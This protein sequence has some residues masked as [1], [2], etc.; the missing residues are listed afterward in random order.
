MDS[1][2]GT[3]SLGLMSVRRRLSADRVGAAVIALVVVGLVVRLVG[4]GSRV[5]HFDEA[6]VAYFGLQ[7]AN[8]GIYEYRP[9]THGPFLHI[10]NGDVMFPL[11]GPSDVSARLI[12][13]LVGAALPAL[14]LL[15]RHRLRPVETVSMAGLL[16]LT[17]VIVYYSRFMRNDLL[18]AAFMLGAFGVFLRYYETRR[19]RYLYAGTALTAL[20]FTTKENAIVYLVVWIGATALIVDHSA[21]RVGIDRQV[22]RAFDRMDDWL[23]ALKH[24]GATRRRWLVQYVAHGTLAVVVFVAIVAFFYLP[25]GP[26]QLSLIEVLYRPTAIGEVVRDGFLEPLERGI[27]DWTGRSDEPATLYEHY[28]RQ[29]ENMVGTITYGGF[30]LFV[31][32][33]LGFFVER[34]RE[35]TRELVMFAGYWGFVSL[36]GYP[37]AASVHNPA[38]LTVH[39]LVPL[40]IPAAVG[41]DWLIGQIQTALDQDDLPV[42]GI[43]GMILVVMTA[44]LAVAGMVGVY[45]QPASHDNP[46]VQY[47]QPES[48]ELRAAL[49]DIEAAV[50]DHDGLDI[51]FYGQTLYDTYEEEDEHHVTETRTITDRLPLPWYTLAMEATV[52]SDRLEDDLVDRLE[53]DRPAVVIS[54]GSERTVLDGHLTEYRVYEERHFPM[55]GESILIYIHEDH[56]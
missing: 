19:P 23:T 24:D 50:D 56:R 2:R 31:L 26:G 17:P 9:I 30:A 12:V 7:Y 4:L 38:W 54:V 3:L 27:F 16:A 22:T 53:T 46:M 20:G 13:A 6:R 21:Y 41:L 1:Y 47:A 52:D 42:A 39:V 44:Q 10:V 37:L 14:A 48:P 34:Y 55:S 18:L 33:V 32:A 25:R 35:R 8:T 49:D 45:Q 43:V 40:S 51:L 5:A 15:F 36:V 29:L 28:F 11:F